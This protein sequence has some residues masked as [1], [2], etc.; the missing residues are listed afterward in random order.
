[1]RFYHSA[2]RDAIGEERRDVGSK[3][4]F[5]AREWA[6]HIGK[7]LLPEWL[8]NTEPGPYASGNTDLLPPVSSERGKEIETPKTGHSPLRTPGV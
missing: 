1:M 7:T 8:Y 6:A 3:L 4:I 2:N 5:W